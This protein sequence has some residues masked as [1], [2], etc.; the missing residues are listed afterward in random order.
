MEISKEQAK[1]TLKEGSPLLIFSAG[2]FLLAIGIFL[3]FSSDKGQGLTGKLVGIIVSFIAILIIIYGRSGIIIIDKATGT[4]KIMRQSVINKEVI[5]EIKFSDLKELVLYKILSYS[6]GSRSGRHGNITRGFSY[7]Y[8]L[9]F[10]DKN[11]GDYKIYVGTATLGS[12]RKSTTDVSIGG[13]NVLSSSEAHGLDMLEEM[14]KAQSMKTPEQQLYE[15]LAKEVADF[16]GINLTFKE[17]NNP[18]NY[19]QEKQEN[20]NKKAEE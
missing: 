20:T 2:M 14:K 13:L 15:N 11:G 9:H 19:W 5:K 12:F 10:F 1:I 3:F 7:I 17:I 16:I 4:I 6:Q 8:E 18:L